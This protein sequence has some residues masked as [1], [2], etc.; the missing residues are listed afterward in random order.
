MKPRI[1]LRW[2][3]DAVQRLWP[4]DKF[5]LTEFI[6]RNP[7]STESK[8]RKV[9]LWSRELLNR[10]QTLVLMRV[11]EFCRRKE[12]RECVLS[13]NN[14]I[15]G[16]D[17]TTSHRVQ[18]GDYLLVEAFVSD[19]SLDEAKI[20]LE[21]LERHECNRRLYTTAECEMLGEVTGDHNTQTSREGFTL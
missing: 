9:V 5:V 3:G 10:H 11:D 20:C 18:D 16:R 13:H 6:I 7:R 19:I 21:R 17:D 2:R 15:W 8:R 1:F 4:E 12:T 14:R